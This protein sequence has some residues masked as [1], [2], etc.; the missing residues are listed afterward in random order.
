MERSSSLQLNTLLH[1]AVE[2]NNK[3][4]VQKLI[5]WNVDIN[6]RNDKGDTPLHLAA[7]GRLDDIMGL[8][9]EKGAKT[10]II[11][12]EGKTFFDIIRNLAVFHEK[13]LTSV[14]RK[15]NHDR[16]LTTETLRVK[17]DELNEE[18]EGKADIV[19]NKP[20]QNVQEQ[21]IELLMDKHLDVVNAVNNIKQSVLFMSICRDY[22]DVLK[23]LIKQLEDVNSA[24]DKKA[25]L[26]QVQDNATMPNG[27]NCEG[28]KNP[29]GVQDVKVDKSNINTSEQKDCEKNGK[30]DQDVGADAK[31]DPNTSDQND[32]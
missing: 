30:A 7:S 28:K 2:Y 20:V 27:L 18:Q 19:N 6:S 31:S 22:L 1:E 13:Q 4:L 3:V 17:K 5:K 29:E 25:T 21:V 11:N 32:K 14:V 24:A 23:S 8:L 15:P 10:D 12:N 9:L 16:N 26:S